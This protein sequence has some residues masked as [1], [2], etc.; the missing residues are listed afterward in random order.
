MLTPIDIRTVPDLV[1]IVEEVAATR[2]PRELKRDNQVVAVLM[3]SG[4][5]KKTSIQDA[6]ALAG[7]WKDIPSEDM[8]ER[9]ARIRHQSKP[10]PPLTLDL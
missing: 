2:I 10:S 6:L 4:I 1:P 5:K 8:E 3:P 7:A 9:L